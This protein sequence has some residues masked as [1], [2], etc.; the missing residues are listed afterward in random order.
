M[1]P[2]TK[3]TETK[4]LNFWP[5]DQIPCLALILFAEKG[6]PYQRI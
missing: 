4:E 3:S 2:V 6:N 5:F 1:S